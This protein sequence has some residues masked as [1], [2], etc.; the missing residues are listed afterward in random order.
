MPSQALKDLISEREWL[1]IPESFV[2]REG[3]LIDT[4]GLAWTLST[5]SGI[6]RLTFDRISNSHIRWSAMRRVMHCAATVSSHAGVQSFL[7]LQSELIAHQDQFGLTDGLSPE[8]IKPRLID[9]MNCVISEARKKHRLWALYR[10]VRWY[11]WCSDNFPELGFCEDFGNE[12]DG[13]IIPGN[14]KGEAVLAEDPEQGPL[15]RTLELLP[16]IYALRDDQSTD[17]DHLQEKAAVALSIAYGRNPT[18]LV[19]LNEGDLKN[20]TEGFEGVS[21]CWILS[22]P[23]IKKGQLNPR[24]SFKDE[25]MDDE[26]VGHLT[27]MIQAN[28]SKA[29]IVRTDKGIVTLDDR[30]LFMRR[31][32]RQ[33]AVPITMAD[34]GGRIDSNAINMLL[35]SFVKRHGIASPITN[36]TLNLTPR[37][38]RYTLATS[39][40]DEG[41]SPREL[42]RILDHT[43][44]QHVAVYFDLKSRIVRHLDSATATRFGGFLKLFKGT[45]VDRVDAAHNGDRDDKHLSFVDDESPTNQGEIGVCGEDSLCHL[46]PPYSCYMCPK[47][48]PL[49]DA[50]HQRVLDCLLSSREKRFVKYENARLGIQLDD[51]IFAVAQV[52]SQCG[53]DATNG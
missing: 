47:F 42:A 52:V 29:A 21:P 14:P 30:P 16:L 18:N 23:R 33:N 25:P 4:G 9:L 43:D 13:M 8:V 26:L 2:C 48:Q 11:V 34:R 40:V 53:S 31:V 49:R 10:S 36:S 45:I 22:M 7:D 32:L 39:L 37:R 5:P 12:I 17:F 35:K 27:A 24:D 20:L 28:K 46:D 15:D 38:F 44:T 50:N 1:D 41:I 51:V 6:R 19:F 3:T